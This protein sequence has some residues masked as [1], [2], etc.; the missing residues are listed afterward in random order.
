VQK[1][2]PERIRDRQICHDDVWKELRAND[3]KRGRTVRGLDDLMA[4]SLEDHP[5]H[6]GVTKSAIPR[7]VV[8][9]LSAS[10]KPT[11]LSPSSGERWVGRLSSLVEALAVGAA[12][13]N[14]CPSR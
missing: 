2:S 10:E 6:H 13:G 5:Q 12:T 7:I 14:P 4:G 8:R 9:Y 1:S 3:V 11:T